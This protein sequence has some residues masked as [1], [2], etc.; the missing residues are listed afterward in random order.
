M[1]FRELEDL[2]GWICCP[3][4]SYSLH[5]YTDNPWI[6]NRLKHSCRI[7]IGGHFAM[8]PYASIKILKCHLKVIKDQISSL[9]HLMPTVRQ[10]YFLNPPPPPP[11]VLLI[12]ELPP[13]PQSKTKYLVSNETD[14]Q[15]SNN[16]STANSSY[17]S[18]MMSS[19]LPG[20]S[21]INMEEEDEER[22]PYVCEI[23]EKRFKT[24]PALRIHSRVHNDRKHFAC[25]FCTKYFKH[26]SGIRKHWASIH[27]NEL[28]YSC[29][30]CTKEFKTFTEERTHIETKHRDIRRAKATK[31]KSLVLKN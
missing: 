23:C 9:L 15:N 6:A 30:Y 27:P 1:I 26:S 13:P 16:M 28:P 20:S 4:Y 19:N 29:K 11:D 25:P 5:F 24:N 21:A 10:E 2:Y 3:V 7:L 31:L 12:K 22:R 17:N 8:D 14:N 18:P